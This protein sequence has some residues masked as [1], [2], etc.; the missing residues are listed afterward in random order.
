MKLIILGPPGAGKGTQAK[1]ISE[2]YHIIHI[3]T[4][5]LLRAEIANKT[6]LGLNA[7]QYTNSGKLVPDSIM[8]ELIKNRL[9]KED[10]KNGFLLDGY[11]RTIPQAESLENLTS[12]DIVINLEV[13]SELLIKRLCGRRSCPTCGSVFHIYSN[14]P[15]KQNLCD[16]CGSELIQRDDDKEDIIRKRLETYIQQT[17]PLIEYYRNKKLLESI[18]GSENIYRISENIDRVLFLLSHS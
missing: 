17:A 7:M 10:A 1:I 4:G 14:P 2:K 13:E 6:P 18:D 12:I 11:P 5:V 8:I 15:L 16:H 9:Q 3:S